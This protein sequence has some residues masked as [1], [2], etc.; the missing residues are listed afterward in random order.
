[1]RRSDA[2]ASRRDYADYDRDAHVRE[3]LEL[4]EM[5]RKKNFHT[6]GS[7]RDRGPKST[8]VPVQ[9]SDRRDYRFVDTPRPYHPGRSR[10]SDL[11]IER[12]YR[13]ETEISDASHRFY[14]RDGNFVYKDRKRGCDVDIRRDYDFSRDA[15]RRSLRVP[16]RIC[17]SVERRV[18]EHMEYEEKEKRMWIPE[19]RVVVGR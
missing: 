9:R 10:S 19:R 7:Y 8:I 12:E 14:D 6:V 16:S 15:E 3:D 4:D 11:V 5:Y 17:R 18:E 2:A 1:M 13:D